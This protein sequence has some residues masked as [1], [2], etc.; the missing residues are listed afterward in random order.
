MAELADLVL[1]NATF[2]LTHGRGAAVELIA[3]EDAVDG[4][5]RRYR[6]S[7]FA[8]GGVDLV[9]VHAPLPVGDDLRLD[10]F[11]FV[12]LTPFRPA[13]LRQQVRLRTAASQVAIVVFPEGLRAGVVMPIE[14]PHPAKCRRSAG[15]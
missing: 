10:A 4:R 9:S 3:F 13:P 14:I 7:S 15:L 6:I 8:Q 1:D 2:L 5:G 12:P 11:R